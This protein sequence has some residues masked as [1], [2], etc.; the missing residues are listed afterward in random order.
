MALVRRTSP[1]GQF[2]VCASADWFERSGFHLP[3]PNLA[4]PTSRISPSRQ[5]SVLVSKASS[6]L[7]CPWIGLAWREERDRGGHVARMD[8]I[9]LPPV[10]NA[11][12]C[13]PVLSVIAR[14]V[15][16]VISWRLLSGSSG[17]VGCYL[18]RRESSRRTYCY[19]CRSVGHAHR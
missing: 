18:S 8:A 15:T 4:P 10:R 1:C 17:D 19:G 6:G 9:S 11:G 7:S 14:G 2:E 16:P 5:T 12:N 3:N 13:R